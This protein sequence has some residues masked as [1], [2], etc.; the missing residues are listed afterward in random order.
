[1]AAGDR[2]DRG[3]FFKDCKSQKGREDVRGKERRGE[4]EGPSTG[5]VGRRVF[6]K[7]TFSKK[8]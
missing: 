6:H 2:K 1:M 5:H 8:N 3:R 4:D 7:N